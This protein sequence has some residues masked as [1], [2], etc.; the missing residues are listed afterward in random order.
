[1]PLTRLFS[2]EC[3]ANPGAIIPIDLLRDCCNPGHARTSCPRAASIE[4]DATQFL[5]ESDRDGIVE[6]AWAIEKNHHPV[7]IGTLQISATTPP[8][9]EPLNHQARAFVAS[10]ARQKGGI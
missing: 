10:Y 4:P 6:V 3:S 2:G 1:M 9:P 7:A 5:I 8:S